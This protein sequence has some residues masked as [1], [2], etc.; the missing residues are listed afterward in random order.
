MSLGVG[1]KSAEES[2]QRHRKSMEE[3]LAA[4]DK[5]FKQE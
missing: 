2:E 3:Q 5:Q 4:I 1:T